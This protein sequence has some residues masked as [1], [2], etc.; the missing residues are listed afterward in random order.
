MDIQENEPFTLS[1]TSREYGLL[2]DA[3][4]ERLQ[5]LH[6]L[7]ARV[8]RISHRDFQREWDGLDRVRQKLIDQLLPSE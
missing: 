1:L 2:Q 6:A 8:G 4:Y 7:N 5:T 3:I